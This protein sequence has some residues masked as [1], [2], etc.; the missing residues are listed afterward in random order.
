[1]FINVYLPFIKGFYTISTHKDGWSIFKPPDAT[2]KSCSSFI[3]G[4]KSL[5]MTSKS[6]ITVNKLFINVYLPFIRGFYIISKN[7]YVYKDL[8]IIGVSNTWMVDPY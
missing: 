3:R 1:M 5:V 8:Y 7:L 6:F 2:F 4:Y